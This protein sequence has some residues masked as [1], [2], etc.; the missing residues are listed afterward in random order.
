MN[1]VWYLLKVQ[2]LQFFGLNKAL[3]AKNPKE[4][5]KW[6]AIF[7]GIIALIVYMFVIS[8]FYSYSMASMFEKIGKMELLLAIMMAATSLMTFMVTIYK[9]NGILFGF[10]DYDIVMSLPIKTSMVVA[11]RVL[12]LYVM[13]LVFSLLLMIP[14]GVVYAMKV[15]PGPLFYVLFI[16]TLLFIPLLPIIAATIIGS[17][18]M[19]ISARFKYANFLNLAMTFA[20]LLIF[21]GGMMNVNGGVE[22]LTNMSLALMEQVNTLYP[23]TG[24]YVNAVCQYSLLSLLLF[25]GISIGAF[26]LY[27]VIVGAK[28]KSINTQLMTKRKNGRYQMAEQIQ[29][30]P[31]KALYRKELK[32]YFS[33]SIYVLNTAFGLVLYT[34]VTIA[35]LFMGTEQISEMIKMPQLSLYIN[36]FA[37]FVVSVF[38]VLSCTT[39]SSISLE[40]KN[41]WI[42]QSSPIAVQTICLSKIA[43][44]LTLTVPVI[45]VN[46]ILLLFVL[47][48]SFIEGI[49]LFAVPLVYTLFIAFMGIVI[50]LK[51]PNFDWTNEVTV[52][53]QSAASL[54]ATFGGLFS[55]GIPFAL[56]M[57]L[58]NINLYIFMLGVIIV[59][60][61]LCIMMYVYMTRK[62]EQ[63]FKAS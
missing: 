6:M 56:L 54:I 52:V 11:S 29:S 25:I 28:F 50:N 44:N 40:G 32:R 2:L 31:F 33:T 43:V 38:I 21:M 7:I 55:I 41:L 12:M 13:N 3:H 19:I 30:S 57:V 53:K 37:P 10:R 8:F 16:V 15:V 24:M 1:K 46:N 36:E 47:Q 23:L 39:M 61:V 51:F 34:V 49:L 14:A 42:L 5:R 26:M 58:P 60:L 20:V 48:T 9:V 62:G 4:K 35:L 27:V 63:V 17:V 22:D 18:I 45:F 59:L